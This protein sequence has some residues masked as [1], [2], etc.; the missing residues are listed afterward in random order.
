[1]NTNLLGIGELSV[2]LGAHYISF[3]SSLNKNDNGFSSVAIDSRKVKKGSL[4]V[5]LNGVSCDGHEFVQAAFNCGA[6]AAMV[7]SSKIESFNLKN[8]AQK[9]GRDLII[10]ENTLKGLQNSARVYLEKFPKLVRIGITGSSG[11]TTTK[12]ITAAI[13]S[14]EKNII[15]NEGNLNSETGLPVSVFEVRSCHEV[16]IF[17][18]GMNRPGE[19]LEIA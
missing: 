1:M 14:C 11:K 4:F 12:E 5:A 13:V 15:K 8:I 9:A 19:I 3:S 6:A 10:V 18:L 2:S 7:E 17:E 16:G